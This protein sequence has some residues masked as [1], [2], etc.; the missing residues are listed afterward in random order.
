MPD[1]IIPFGWLEWPV[2]VHWGVSDIVV[3]E[4]ELH[5]S[6]PILSYVTTWPVALTSN[7]SGFNENLRLPTAPIGGINASKNLTKGL[8]RWQYT[9]KT[10]ANDTTG[11]VFT[12]IDSGIYNIQTD[13]GVISDYVDALGGHL[14]PFTLDWNAFTLVDSDGALRFT[15]TDATD[16]NIQLQAYMQYVVEHTFTGTV[17]WWQENLVSILTSHTESDGTTYH[18]HYYSILFLNLGKTKQLLGKGTL[19]LDITNGGYTTF[20]FAATGS[21]RVSTWRKQRLFPAGPLNRLLN[22]VKA[23]G[24]DSQDIIVGSD[25]PQALKS[26]FLVNLNTLQITS[27]QSIIS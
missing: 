22:I 23:R 11:L 18:R 4:L 24:V 26:Q 2:A 19:Q 1:N 15:G 27:S 20:T 8:T 7:Y 25:F 9:Q 5:L 10:T 17:S 16:F 21:M 14:V 3:I 6:A 13:R 12:V